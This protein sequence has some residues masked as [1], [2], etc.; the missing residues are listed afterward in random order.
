[1]SAETRRCGRESPSQVHGRQTSG[2]S[3][4]SLRQPDRAPDQPRDGR[5]DDAE[6]DRE[7]EQARGSD[8][9]REPQRAG[10]AD[11]PRWS[12]TRPRNEVRTWTP[13]PSTAA[14]AVIAT[15]G[16]LALR[17]TSPPAVRQV[18]R[19]QGERDRPRQPREHPARAATGSRPARPAPRAGSARPAV[20]P[21]ESE[22][23]TRSSTAHARA[24]PTV[25]RSSAP[26]GEGLVGALGRPVGLLVDEVVVPAEHRLPDQDRGEDQSDLARGAAPTRRPRRPSRAR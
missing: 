9:Q 22:S 11:R 3:A 16:G 23:G 17:A 10:V 1:M 21:L 13:T 18:R 7:H 19:V 12:S 2:R 26:G 20:I 24:K 5:N 4:G 14:T 25:P 8:P 15:V 6:G